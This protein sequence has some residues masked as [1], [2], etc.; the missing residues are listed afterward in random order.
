MSDKFDGIKFRQLAER[1]EGVR[2]R[3]RRISVE[4]TSTTRKQGADLNLANQYKSCQVYKVYGEVSEWSKEHAWKVCI[5]KGIEGS[6]PSLTA[7]VKSLS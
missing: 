6:N 4:V 3:T 1:P 2:R 7:I 5:S